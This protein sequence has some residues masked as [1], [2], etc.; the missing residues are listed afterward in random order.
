MSSMIV[1]IL[2]GLS[3]TFETSSNNALLRVQRAA[4][5]DTPAAIEAAG[6]KADRIAGDF[7]ISLMFCQ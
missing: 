5:A 4:S 2:S 7:T 6:T 3:F 1:S